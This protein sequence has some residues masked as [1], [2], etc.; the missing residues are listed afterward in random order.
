MHGRK[1]KNYLIQLKKVGDVVMESFLVELIPEFEELGKEGGN[2][3]HKG[4]EATKNVLHMGDL[5]RL[6][7]MAGRRITH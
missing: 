6:F 3:I 1:E 2:S 4:I 5:C 7:G